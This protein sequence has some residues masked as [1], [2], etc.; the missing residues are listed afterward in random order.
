MMTDLSWHKTKTLVCISAHEAMK[1]YVSSVRI[2]SLH[3]YGSPLT[4]IT[5]LYIINVI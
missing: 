3:L 5:S 4:I 1:A 2:S